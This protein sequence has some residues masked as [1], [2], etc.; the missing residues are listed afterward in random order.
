[1]GG[2]VHGWA[3]T[4][5]LAAVLAAGL[6]VAAG[7]LVVGGAWA[8]EA[9]F[10]LTV[11]DHRWEP[12][13]LVVPAGKMIKLEITNADPTPEEF[14]SHSLKREKIIPGGATITIYLG[15]LKPGTYEFVGEFHEDTAKGKI[16]AK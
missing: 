2:T 3:R 8:D 14:E 11:K 9:A 7:F 15:A 5:V 1:M 12:A 4:A 10:K 16:I 13:E 6:A